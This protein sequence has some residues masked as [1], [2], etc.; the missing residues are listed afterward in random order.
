MQKL[1]KEERIIKMTAVKEIPEQKT[2]DK[3]FSSLNKQAPL[4][5]GIIDATPNKEYPLRIL[6]RY[7][8]LC[9]VYSSST[10]NFPTKEPEKEENA[11][12]K[13]MNSLVKERAKILDRAIQIIIKA[14]DAGEFNNLD[15]TYE[16]AWKPERDYSEY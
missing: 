4:E 5:A 2:P 16:F 3:D 11:L 1:K 8:E 10:S 15:L 7:R 13:S 6:Q 12:C 9:N 14:I